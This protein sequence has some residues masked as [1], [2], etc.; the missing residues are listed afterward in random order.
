MGTLR[1][2]RHY[3]L[4]VKGGKSQMTFQ[5]PLAYKEKWYI[6]RFPELSH[7]DVARSLGRLFKAH[8][9]GARSRMCVYLFRQT[10]EYRTLREKAEVNE[11]QIKAES[12]KATI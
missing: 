4:R 7:G 6:A 9:G 12:S 8:N 3:W 5:T 11:R 10:E 1:V 2:L